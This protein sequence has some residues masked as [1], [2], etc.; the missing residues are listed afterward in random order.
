ML[1]GR[2]ART[3][4]RGEVFWVPTCRVYTW[5]FSSTLLPAE[6]GNGPHHSFRPGRRQAISL[7]KLF[8]NFAIDF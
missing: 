4:N 8:A 2:V 3:V 5:V 6:P 7:C 1:F